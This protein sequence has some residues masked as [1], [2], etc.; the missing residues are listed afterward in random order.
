MQAER[1][2]KNSFGLCYPTLSQNYVNFELRLRLKFCL[3]FMNATGVQW[4]LGEGAGGDGQRKFTNKQ[5]EKPATFSYPA[6]CCLLCG[7][8]GTQGYAGTG[9]Q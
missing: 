9:G 5:T 1:Q 3:I 7:A 8:Q 6:L 2:T 4:E